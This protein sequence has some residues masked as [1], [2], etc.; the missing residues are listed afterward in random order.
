LVGER[1]GEQDDWQARLELGARTLWTLF[2][3]HP[4]L[5]QMSSLSRPLPLSSL[6][7]H[8]DW[9]LSALDG[10]GL[11]PTTMLNLHIVLYT[12]VHGMAVN[13]E[14]EAQAEAASGMSAEHWMDAHEP[15]FDA[16]TVSGRY[17]TFGRVLGSL[18]EDGY[19]L[20]LDALF[21]LGLR[22]LIEGFASLIEPGL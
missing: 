5:A 12:Y 18:A 14:R 8:A 3:R 9:A 13:L 22:A 19:D 10:L 16:I 20:D 17:P 4:W 1:R 2:R 21:E 15:A 6:A 7:V 11:S